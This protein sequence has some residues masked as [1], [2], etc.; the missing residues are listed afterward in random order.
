MRQWPFQYLILLLIFLL[1]PSLASARSLN[2][3]PSNYR[4]IVQTLRPGDVLTLAPGQYT[5]GLPV[6]NLHGAPGAPIV[7]QGADRIDRPV[8]LGREGH[9]T[10]SIVNS[11]HVVIRNLILD[12]RNLPVDG[13]KA[14]GH[15][16]FA[17]H[18]TLENLRIINHGYNVQIVGI[19]TKC[20]AWGWVIR[21]NEI[22][23]AGTGMY[24][25]NSNGEDVFV[26]GLI[27]HN[28]VRDT[29]GYNI[30]I[31]HQLKRDN[32]PGMPVKQL[33]SV[34]RHNVFSKAGHVSNKSRARPNLLLG[35]FPPFGPG[36]ADFY[37]VYSNFFHQNLFESLMQGEGNIIF[38]NN[39]MVNAHG[40][41]I[42]IFPHNGVPKLIQ[43]FNN[44][45]LALGTGISISGADS[46]Y[47]QTVIANAVFASR[48]IIG[49]EKSHNITAS[50]QDAVFYLNN[51]FSE[52][53]ALDLY[54]QIGRL[55][56]TAPFPPIVQHDF[57]NT[58]RDGRFVG[59]YSGEGK[60]PGWLPHL[61]RKPR[62]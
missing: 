11:R 56:L 51:P 1:A 3:D 47:T 34:I 38:F 61:E 25:G 16:E 17:H 49:G 52:P 53:G 50:F 9:N 31:K 62:N 10:V 43:I 6:F 14:E 21:D 20:P 32:A 29:L 35:H 37:L 2:A 24:L 42:N 46:L 19:S 54:P 26:S 28:L 4:D 5:R 55:Q 45:I 59:A 18:I 58:R 41:A 27:E 48:P 57:N 44:T 40:R 7:I 36:D 13:V 60:N 22:L 39:I 15:S 30:Q 8:F 12:G 23:G 33:A